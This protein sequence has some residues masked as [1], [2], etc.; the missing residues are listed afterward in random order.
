MLG[1]IVVMIH[2]CQLEVDDSVL[3]GNVAN[4]SPGINRAYIPGHYTS[5]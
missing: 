2:R 5:Y 4:D 1:M 3:G